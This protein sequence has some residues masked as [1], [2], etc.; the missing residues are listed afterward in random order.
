MAATPARCYDL[1]SSAAGL[2]VA[3]AELPVCYKQ[4]ALVLLGSG[5]L[6]RH[7]CVRFMFFKMLLT[8]LKLGLPP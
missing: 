4:T 2:L 5:S 7:R 8:Q 1:R 3:F 6:G